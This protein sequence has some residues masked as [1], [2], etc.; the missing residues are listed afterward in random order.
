[1]KDNPEDVFLKSSALHQLVLH[2]EESLEELKEAYEKDNKE[3]F[4]KLRATIVKTQK[5]IDKILS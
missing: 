4:A 2:V 5:E 1:M 3:E